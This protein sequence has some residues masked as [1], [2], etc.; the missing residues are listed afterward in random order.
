MNEWQRANLT[1]PGASAPPPAVPGFGEA[2][3]GLEEAD[4]QRVVERC[5]SRIPGVLRR[6]FEYCECIYQGIEVLRLL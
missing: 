6:R 5:H 1:C 4:I 3:G 2:R